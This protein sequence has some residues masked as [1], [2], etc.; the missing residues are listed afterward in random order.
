MLIETVCYWAKEGDPKRP[1]KNRTTPADRCA[2]VPFG[3]RL[4]SAAG[5]QRCQLLTRC[6]GSGRPL[7]RSKRNRRPLSAPNTPELLQESV[8]GHDIDVM[9]WEVQI[10]QD[11]GCQA[12]SGFHVALTSSKSAE[13]IMAVA[14][15]ERW[16]AVPCDRAGSSTWSRSAIENRP[17]PAAGLRTLSCL[18]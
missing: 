16:R 9:P 4:T 10:R 7:A 17:H 6:G 3:N 15:A 8:E 13:A 12:V 11:G 2:A 1:A 14:E 18:L 5:T